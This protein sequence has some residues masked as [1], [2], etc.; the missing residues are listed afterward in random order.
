MAALTTAVVSAGAAVY[1]AK[2]Q[3]DTGRALQ[4][5][6]RQAGEQQAQGMR[7]AV[8][9]MTP[10]L[11]EAARV[12]AEA[13][14]RAADLEIA[15]LGD[16]RQ[17]YQDMVSGT[18]DILNSGVPQNQGLVNAFRTAQEE[19]QQKV[20]EG[21]GQ[22]GTE[23]AREL[24]AAG[25]TYEQAIQSGRQYLQSNDAPGFQ[26]GTNAFRMQLA[27]TG[28]LGPEAQQEFYDNYKNSPKVKYQLDQI[29][30][31]AGS[32]ASGGNRLRALQELIT[33][34]DDGYF[35]QLG[36]LA[37][38]GQRFAERGADLRMR[39]AE[40]ELGLA[41]LGSSIE[42]NLAR[43]LGGIE[44]DQL[45]TEAGLTG[46]SITGQASALS[47]ASMRG[48]E[49]RAAGGLGAA[50]TIVA[51]LNDFA[52]AAG[53]IWGKESPALDSEKEKENG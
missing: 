38:K 51:G 41:G 42:S 47:G 29:A 46:Q 52:R 28:A 49:A 26:S 12:R 21:A 6:E 22:F 45:T 15:G 36:T 48:A 31:L 1:S 4:K 3:S 10:M 24:M 53:D 2:K 9:A 32:G 20:Q 18:Y 27:M 16:A 23:Y 7:N 39:Q 40:T 8:G 43:Q 30:R 13:A 19:F 11:Q 50:S 5:A 25:N 33:F 17:I 37:E 35:Q 44:A 14:Q 34:N